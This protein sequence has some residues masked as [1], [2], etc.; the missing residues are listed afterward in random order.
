[1]KA[2][3]DRIQVSLSLKQNTWI[4]M[5]K[6]HISYFRTKSD[7]FSDSIKKIQSLFS[8]KLLNN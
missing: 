6:S 7:R 2:D 4:R 1:M 5:Q 8:H 3:M